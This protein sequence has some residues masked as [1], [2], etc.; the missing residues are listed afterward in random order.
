MFNV[1]ILIYTLGLI[2]NNYIKLYGDQYREKV[3]K[4]FLPVMEKYLK[5]GQYSNSNSPGRRAPGPPGPERVRP[6]GLFLLFD[7][8]LFH[9][10]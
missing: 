1:T 5:L 9:V 3:P 10:W 4:Y 7:S 8:W 6:R 2:T